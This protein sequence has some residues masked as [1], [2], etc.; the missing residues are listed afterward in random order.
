ML[1]KVIAYIEQHQLL[2]RQGSVIVAVSGG[3]D[4]LCLLHLLR[5]I[6]EPDGPY[7][8]LSL[9]AVHLNHMLR[10]TESARDARAVATLCESWGI[11][12][13]VGEVD[14][15]ALAIE[16]KRSLEDAARLARYRFLREVAHGRRIAVAHHADDQAETILLHWLRG[17]GLDGLT[18]MLPQQQ[19]IIRPLLGIT[20]AETLAY[21]LEHGLTPIEDQSNSDP[22]FLRNRIRHEVL[23]L[24]KELNPG[25]Q[26]TL[27]RNAEVI[28]VDLAWLEEQVDNCW[29]ATVVAEQP[30]SIKLAIN[31]LLALPLS[32]QRHLLRRV[33]ANLCGGQSPLE[34]RH[35]L[36]IEDLLINPDSNPQRTLH[37][38]R[39]LHAVQQANFVTFIRLPANKARIAKAQRADLSSTNEKQVLLPIPGQADL[40]G[41][42]WLV[43]AD[44]LPQ[45]LNAKVKAALRQRDWPET[46]RLLGQITPLTAYIDG[47][48]LGSHLLVRTR[49]PG[50]RIQPLGMASEKK[51]QDVFVDTY[52]PSARRDSTPLF[53]SETTCLWV[54]GL[55]LNHRVRLNEQTELIVR[56]SIQKSS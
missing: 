44:V 9:Q 1:E 23:P 8:A 52:V 7:A 38:P 32:L 47:Q 27:L 43:Q 11:P 12:C 56:L 35:L 16:E 37:L 25:I 50:D 55:C 18:G 22:R 20:R 28:R 33:T 6:C 41:T 46:W 10:G 45:E 42:P 19:D 40:P 3:T 21:C 15:I 31:A 30:E 26:R 24:L 13:T 2:P 14:V 51:I 17:S 5:Q 29:P 36:L 39:G 54:A 49:R 34:P 53:F 48:S 4:S